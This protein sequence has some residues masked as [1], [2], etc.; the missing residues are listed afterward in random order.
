VRK[1]GQEKKDSCFTPIFCPSSLPS[2]HPF[3]A[4]CIWAFLNSRLKDPPK[5]FCFEIAYTYYLSDG[6][7]ASVDDYQLK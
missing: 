4:P 1:S 2:F 5:Q 3:G 6:L 7:Y